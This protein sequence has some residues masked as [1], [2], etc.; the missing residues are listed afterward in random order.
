MSAY[1]NVGCTYESSLA[2]MLNT[3]PSQPPSFSQATNTWCTKHVLASY[4]YLPYRGP[5]IPLAISSLPLTA[6]VRF[7]AYKVA[8]MSS[9]YPCK[10]IV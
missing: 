8:A 4:G 5:Y 6:Q 2:R 7:R 9:T 10:N 1:Q 3:L